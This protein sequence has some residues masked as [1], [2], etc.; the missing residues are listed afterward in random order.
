MVLY[1]RIKRKRNN[2]SLTQSTISEK[3]LTFVF[4]WFQYSIRQAL[5]HIYMDI[6]FKKAPKKFVGNKEL[7]V[8]L[9]FKRNSQI[10]LLS[11]KRHRVDFP[12]HDIVYSHQKN[13][14]SFE[15]WIVSCPMNIVK[16]SVYDA[17]FASVYTPW[18]P[19]G[20]SR[21]PLQTPWING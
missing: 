6:N 20:Q 1:T 13:I 11:E 12:G 3:K 10:T 9:V 16:K 15:F 14:R 2:K 4:C 8:P 19:W 17:T 7:N 5:S 18:P 21:L